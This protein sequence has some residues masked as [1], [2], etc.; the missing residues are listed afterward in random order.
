MEYENP[1]IE[2]LKFRECIRWSDKDSDGYQSWIRRMMAVDRHF[3]KTGK[4]LPRHRFNKDP[5]KP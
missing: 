1:H 4:K 3:L 5:D 2:A